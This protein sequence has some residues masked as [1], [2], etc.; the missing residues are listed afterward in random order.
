MVK[1]VLNAV[2]IHVLYVTFSIL[3]TSDGDYDDEVDMMGLEAEAWSVTV[4]K[5]TLK[6]MSA[7]DIKRQ[8]HIWGLFERISYLLYFGIQ[9][10]RHFCFCIK[11]EK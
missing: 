10:S 3:G 4:D 8:D 6:K 9:R 11:A 7:K 2:C 5:K 1:V